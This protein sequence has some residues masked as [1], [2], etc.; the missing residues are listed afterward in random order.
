MKKILEQSTKV[1]LL[2]FMFLL[3]WI[4]LNGLL[5]YDVIVYEFNPIILSIGIVL[6]ITILVVIYKKALPKIE[7]HKYLP[8]ILICCFSIIC[9]ITALLLRVNP[10]WDMGNVFQMAKNYVMIG[11]VVDSYL[12]S[13]PNNM[14]LTIIY[15][16]IFKICSI[17]PN[18][19]YVVAATIFNSMVM[20][21]CVTLMYLIAN[22]MLGRKK[23]LMILL[24]AIFTTPFYMHA[25]IYYSDSMSAFF[26]LLIFYL[27]LYIQEKEV[28]KVTIL[29]Q[30][31]LGAILLVGI[32]IKITTSFVAIA[33]I[34]YHILN[35]KI[36]E[37]AI[38]NAFVI[39]TLVIG[40]IIFQLLVTPFVIKNKGIIDQYEVP[41]IH[42]IMMGLKG[43]GGYN[44]EDYRYTFSFPTYDKKKAADIIEIKSRLGS[45]NAN[46]FIKHL[47]EK[48]KFAWTDG[49]YY[50]PE[51]LRR[52]PVQENVFH[53]IVLPSGKYA[54]IYKYL[55][56]IMHIS[57]LILILINSYYIFK[58]KHYQK[59]DMIIIITMFGL[60]IFLLLWE[61]RSRYIFTIVPLMIILQ[62]NGIEGLMNYRQRIKEEK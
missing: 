41:I 34:V 59:T 51:K 55:P 16:F 35:I 49:T 45:Y 19:D 50:A 44:E 53:Q 33:I 47:T 28:S 3:S 52:Q 40:F 27:Y 29:A 56:Q 48:L 21:G 6:Y 60:M 39:P 61:N 26:T 10:S 15:I 43:N 25:A 12:Y 9:V 23:A 20:I 13:Y 1:I 32:K 8:G 22:K 57:M 37:I 5:D 17:I 11:N 4:I 31:L 38:K 54:N 62:V 30:I 2:I 7:N 24:I 58:N 36:K 46:S 18:I 42:W 14:M